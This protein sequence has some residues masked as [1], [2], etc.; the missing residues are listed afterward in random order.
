MTVPGFE[1]GATSGP[2]EFRLQIVVEVSD[3][4]EGAPRP[5]GA[6]QAAP[7]GSRLPQLLESAHA[8]LQELSQGL[9]VRM[10]SFTSPNGVRLVAQGT[11]RSED[12]AGIRAV[13]AALA[14]K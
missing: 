12:L 5:Q 1:A 9:D 4:A 6:G 7:A 13:A 14:R 8:L 11:A 10:A 3:P 2:L